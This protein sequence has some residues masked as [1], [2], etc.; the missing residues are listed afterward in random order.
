MDATVISRYAGMGGATA[1]VAAEP[2]RDLSHHAKS[3]PA[4]SDGRRTGAHI[5][6]RPE[7]GFP[8]IVS[9]LFRLSNPIQQAGLNQLV[10]AIGLASIASLPTLRE[11]AGMSGGCQS[12]TLSRRISP[13][14]VQQFATDGQ[15]ADLRS[16]IRSAVSMAASGRREALRGAAI[17]IAIQHVARRT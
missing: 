9:T 14:Q 17:T 12:V 2:Q 3:A 7:P 15:R 5:P 13:G 8:P 10:G 16:S 6:I 4:A 1:S 11:L